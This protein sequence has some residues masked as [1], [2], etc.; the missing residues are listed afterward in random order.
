[1]LIEIRYTETLRLSWFTLFKLDELLSLRLKF[2]KIRTI[3]SNSCLGF[4]KGLDND[5]FADRKLTIKSYKKSYGVEEPIRSK[6]SKDENCHRSS[7]CCNWICGQISRG[8]RLKAEWTLCPRFFG[9]PLI[10]ALTAFE[11]L[12]RQ[13]R[14]L[15]QQKN[16]LLFYHKTVDFGC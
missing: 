14:C 4:C 5:F 7:C 3:W 6:S 15:R 1:M 13:R 2:S 9:K 10:T 16:C 8:E 11:R 12:K